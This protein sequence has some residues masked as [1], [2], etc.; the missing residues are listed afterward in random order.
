[1]SQGFLPEWL[2]R[3]T[4]A[5]IAISM[6]AVVA[7]ANP[8]ES[9]R[10]SEIMYNHP[11]GND[12]EY[13]EL[14]NASETETLSLDGVEI[15]EGIRYS[16]P[17]GVTMAPNTRIVV[18][19]NPGP[20][21]NA[22]YG[23]SGLGVFGPYDAN[24]ANGGERIKL[25]DDGDEIADFTYN[26]NRGWP[27]A[28]D[29]SGHSIVPL[30]LANQRDGR[31]DSGANW[32]ASTFIDG[33]P[34]APEPTKPEGPVVNEIAPRTTFS[35]PSF[36]AY[37]SND[38]IELFN[39]ETT[40][41]PLN[42]LFLSDDV[43]NLAKWPVP[44]GSI[45]GGGFVSFDEIT[46]FNNPIGSGFG[47]SNAGETI[48]LSHLPASGA[49]RVV[50]CVTYPAVGLNLNWGRV[51]DG[52][53]F[54]SVLPPTRDTVNGGTVGEVQL[55]EFM[56]HPL[57]LLTGG[58]PIDNTAQEFIELY[59]PGQTP[60][61][62]STT[63]GPYELKGDAD[64]LFPLNTTINPGQSI[65]VVPFDPADSVARGAFEM[66]YGIGAPVQMVGPW[67][68]ELANGGGRITL[69]KPEPAEDAGDP[70]V[71]VLVD[72]V[73][74]G[75][76]APW[77]PTADGTGN[78]L[79]R[80]SELDPSSDPANW[81]G[82]VPTPGRSALGAV[83]APPVLSPIADQNASTG[84]T[85]SFIVNATDPNPGQTLTY[86]L[87]NAPAGAS[88]DGNGTFSWTPAEVGTFTITVVV[89]DDGSPPESDSQDVQ[90][91]VIGA[92]TPP[93]IVLPTR[94]AGLPGTPITFTATANDPDPGQTLAFA[95][96]GG[97]PGSSIDFLTGEFSWTPA[98]ADLGTTQ[99]VTIAVADSGNP[100]GTDF[101]MVQLIVGEAPPDAF[102]MDGCALLVSPER[103]QISFPSEPGSSYQVETTS[104][105]PDLPTTS[106]TP[107]PVIT[108]TGGT[109]LIDVPIDAQSVLFYRI[110][111]N[112]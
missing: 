101:G 22:K 41:L 28:G 106:W 58:E 104:E 53:P 57:N 74:Y 13:I 42:D 110:V 84:A 7:M 83:N 23:L 49:R 75:D 93:Q 73:V 80:V 1:M 98:P 69:V 94:V 55:S 25:S 39:P 86:S 61:L 11:D 96:I 43:D 26:D 47:L 64:F 68:N 15:S 16:F 105:L 34:T 103:I 79:N 54:F 8:E 30:V 10:I 48:F 95:A 65:V 31:L 37:D 3:A 111:A 107:G 38:W 2:R 32:V 17:P 52:D 90:I 62:L 82:G 14:L 63:E 72:E 70:P 59:N 40:T 46:G 87:A 45:S 89:T 66:A 20:A 35:N 50:D 4:T 24:L 100:S 19:K 27:C 51:P 18:A 44:A 85:L 76:S 71:E 78:S 36:P 88:V 6:V 108:A 102:V 91:T 97:P 109:S 5:I 112:P 81:T 77:D 12:F 29:G 67:T 9:L 56:Y 92:N 99:S 60:A 33:S 21:F